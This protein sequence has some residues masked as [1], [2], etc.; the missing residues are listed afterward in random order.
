MGFLFFPKLPSR[1]SD[2]EEKEDNRAKAQRPWSVV[3]TFLSFFFLETRTDQK[4]TFS[5]FE[6]KVP[7]TL[8]YLKGI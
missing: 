6:A 4:K 2:S 5:Y 8:E 7:E 1:V 3:N